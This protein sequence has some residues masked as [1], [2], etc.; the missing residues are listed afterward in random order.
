MSEIRFKNH[1][2]FEEC[3]DYYEKEEINNPSIIRIIMKSNIQHRFNQT[4]DED[5]NINNDRIGDLARNH[6]IFYENN[7]LENKEN[8]NN[9]IILNLDN[10]K[11]N[12]HK[13]NINFFII[14]DYFHKYGKIKYV[15]NDLMEY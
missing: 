7:D 3:D 15:S 8:H 14:H 10:N 11:N 5:R 2:Y 4:Q 1:I 6:N 12:D 9:K 13:N